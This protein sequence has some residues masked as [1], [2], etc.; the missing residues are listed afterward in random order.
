[1]SNAGYYGWQN[2]YFDYEPAEDAAIADTT[3]EASDITIS[4][5]ECGSGLVTFGCDDEGREWIE[6]E[7]CGRDFFLDD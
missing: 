7:E 6:C 4:C 2:D 1:M 5:P 3:G